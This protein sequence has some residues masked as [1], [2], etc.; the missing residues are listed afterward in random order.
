MKYMM[1]IHTNWQSTISRTTQMKVCIC[2]SWPLKVMRAKLEPTKKGRIGRSTLRTMVRIMV[3]NFSRKFASDLKRVQTTPSP[4]SIAK[5]SVDIV[6]TVGKFRV[7]I[8][9]SGSSLAM[10]FVATIW[11]SG[12]T[13]RLA[14][15]EKSAAPIDER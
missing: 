3:W 8:I 1:N 6:S 4:R 2:P 11:S 7:S 12:T 15:M 9:F 5:S 13:A 14:K 10:E